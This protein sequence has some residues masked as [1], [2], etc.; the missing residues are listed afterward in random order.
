MAVSR[1][2]EITVDKEIGEVYALIENEFRKK[3]ETIME[4]RELLEETGIFSIFFKR[5][6][7]SNGEYLTIDLQKTEE[8]R[9][10]I[11]MV[12]RSKVEK[13]VYD[14]GKNDKNIRLILELMGVVKKREKKGVY[15][16]GRK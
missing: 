14:W 16:P 8:D 4:E 15:Y 3:T 6:I 10:K 9:T 12:S 11:S 7:L 2:K 1:E 5:G 13:T